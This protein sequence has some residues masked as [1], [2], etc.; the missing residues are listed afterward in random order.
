[1]TLHLDDARWRTAT[2]AR[3]VDE[4]H[5]VDP[6]WLD[7]YAPHDA[8]IAAEKA[9]LDALAESDPEVQLDDE[10][11][12]AGALAQWEQPG[13]DSPSSRPRWAMRI[14]VVTGVLAA[15]VAAGLL[16]SAGPRAPDVSPEDD[17]V[18]RAGAVATSPEDVAS[19][20]SDA[21]KDSDELPEPPEPPDAAPVPAWA[22]HS[23]SLVAKAPEDPSAPLP[24]GVALV[25]AGRLCTSSTPGSEICLED[26]SR[27][28]I[29]D[30]H[31]LELL[32]G[33]AR[34][35]TGEGRAPSIEVDDMRIE[36]EGPTMYV[37]EY[38]AAGWSL[39]VED[40]APVMHTQQ[41]HTAVQAGQTLS[42]KV[43]RTRPRRSTPDPRARLAAARAVRAAG[44]REGAAEIYEALIAAS[45]RSPLARV[46]TV[47]LGQLYLELGR[48]KK[49]RAAFE[50]YLA[51]GPGTLSEDAAFGRL[52]ALRALDS[53]ALGPATKKFLARYPDGAYAPRVR[54]WSD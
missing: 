14:A 54:R 13:L 51:R 40:G 17:Q 22:V 21:P 16:L 43:Q 9:L 31:G 11:V 7:D 10:A 3:L 38:E 5:G 30:D 29:L 32:E 6:A 4:P 20:V 53:S 47:S 15:G 23:G 1:M 45:P 12:I 46:A 2:T 28:E 44:D 19:E 26:G 39:A 33:T 25:A 37:I 18:A 34:V 8:E 24:R 52:R 41:T 35:H 27:F 49:A 48:P 36:S 50:R 42:G